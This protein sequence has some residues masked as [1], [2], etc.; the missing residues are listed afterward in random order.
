MAGTTDTAQ[1]PGEND[2]DYFL[3]LQRMQYEETRR[4]NKLLEDANRLAAEAARVEEERARK[5]AAEAAHKAKIEQMEADLAAAK[6]K[7]AEEDARL[8][9]V[10]KFCFAKLPWLFIGGVLAVGSVFAFGMV[11]PVATTAVLAGAATLAGSYAL[12]SYQDFRR[13]RRAEKTGQPV[14][15]KT[16]ALKKLGMGMIPALVVGAFSGVGMALYQKA[17]ELPPLPPKAPVGT[18]RPLASVAPTV[19]QAPRSTVKPMATVAPPTIIVTAPQADPKGTAEGVLADLKTP[20]TGVQKSFMTVQKRN[21]A[22]P[23]VFNMPIPQ[24]PDG[25]TYVLVPPAGQLKPGS[26]ATV[27]ICQDFRSKATFVAYAP[28]KVN[29]DGTFAPGTATLATIDQSQTCVANFKKGP[30]GQSLRQVSA[31]P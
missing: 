4:Q 7:R 21:Y 28:I 16:G 24:Q 11:Y 27:G 13:E 3:R 10:L 29:P 19:S 12:T 23:A 20:D 8:G 31:R 14:P 22:T 6:R 5:A 15:P 18:V 25:H 26:T 1:Q 9:G 17:H 2:R 30:H